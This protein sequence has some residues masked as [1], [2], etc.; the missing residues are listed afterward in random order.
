MVRSLPLHLLLLYLFHN[1]DLECS[2]ICLG[3]F[4]PGEAR[5]STSTVVAN[6]VDLEAGDGVA[7]IQTTTTEATT[8]E[9][10]DHRK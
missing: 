4:C 6:E 10:K 8:M 7:R 2:L 1:A 9:S 3:C 5:T